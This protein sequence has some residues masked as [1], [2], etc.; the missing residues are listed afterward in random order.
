M[1]LHAVL[2]LHFEYL[3][4]EVLELLDHYTRILGSSCQL[5]VAVCGDASLEQKLD[6]LSS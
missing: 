3:L 5:S 6:R 2:T 4:C 1:T